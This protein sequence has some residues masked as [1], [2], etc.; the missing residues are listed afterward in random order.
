MD[1]FEKHIR[2]IGEFDGQLVIGARD[3][4]AKTNRT[5]KGKPSSGAMT[6]EYRSAITDTEN[7]RFQRKP[8]VWEDVD[9]CPVCGSRNRDFYLARFALDIYRCADCDHRYMSPRIKFDVLSEMYGSDKTAAEIY[10]SP[11]QIEIDQKKYGYGVELIDTFVTGSRNKIMDIGCG[12]GVFLQVAHAEGWKRCIGVD[13]NKLY[14]SRYEDIDGI[15]FIM[16]AFENLSPDVVGNDYQCISMWSV[17]EH[18]YDLPGALAQVHRL[19]ADGGVF[20]VLVPNVI[21]L[22]TRLMREKSP[23]FNWKHVSH[24]TPDSLRRLMT[25]N[26]FEEVHMETVI[27]EIDNIKSYMSGEHPYEGF[28]D[29]DGLFD[30]ITPEYIHR[31]MLGSR[32]IGIFRKS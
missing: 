31:N 21:S 32:M 30:F 17:L 3:F 23:C 13:L 20:F 19:L 18:L 28:G 9:E 1:S 2:R 29:P 15:Q 16:A 10:T 4:N 26:G 5:G 6:D 27:T 25:D 7:D 14:K 11:L 12:A 8:D 24:F 22:A